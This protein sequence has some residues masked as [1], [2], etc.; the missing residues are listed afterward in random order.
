[1]LERAKNCDDQQSAEGGRETEHEVLGNKYVLNTQTNERAMHT[2][3][4]T[5]PFASKTQEP[6][7]KVTPLELKY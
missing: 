5:P 7:Y 6:A 4:L 1:M 3:T 2:K